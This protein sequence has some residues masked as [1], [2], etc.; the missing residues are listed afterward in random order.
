MGKGA[1]RNL[2]NSER[3]LARVNPMRTTAFLC[4][5][6]LAGCASIDV[7]GRSGEVR[8][9]FY[10]A[11]KPLGVGS[12]EVYEFEQGQRGA[13]VCELARISQGSQ[14]SG[15]ESWVYGRSD[16][17]DYKLFRCEALQSGRRYGANVFHS[18]HCML[19]AEFTVLADGT[20]RALGWGRNFCWM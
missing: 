17:P 1:G 15:L 5:L 2:G 16:V 12:I 14:P 9:D 11:G 6:V 3:C 10:P 4:L 8:L 7:T 13:T 19:T 18:S 20:V